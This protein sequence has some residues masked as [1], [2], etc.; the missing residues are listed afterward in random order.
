MPVRVGLML[1]GLCAVVL[2]PAP[3]VAQTPGVDIGVRAGLHPSNVVASLSAGGLSGSEGS[4]RRADFTGGGFLG[5][6]LTSN[7]DVQVEGLLSGRGFGGEGGQRV[8]YLEVPVLARLPIAKSAGGVVVNVLGGATF[9]VRL[10]EA[11]TIGLDEAGFPPVNGNDLVR[12]VDTALTIGTSITRGAFVFDVRY[13]HGLTNLFTPAG[14]DFIR[15]VLEEFGSAAIPPPGPLPLSDF[16]F[17]LKHR[18]FALTVGY[19]F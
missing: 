16:D 13:V 11:S 7:V 5:K 1:V 12:R 17:S 2:L 6:A 3:A 15:E 8:W 10:S 18:A 9:G 14:V 4:P 19:R